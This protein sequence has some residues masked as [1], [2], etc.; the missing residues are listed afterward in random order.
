MNL[1]KI[2]KDFYRILFVNYAY[3][4][5]LFHILLNVLPPFLRKILFKAVLGKLGKKVFIDTNVYFRY[6]QKVEIGSYVSINR[7]CEFYPSLYI[8]DA[9]IR[10]GNNVRFGPNVKCYTAGHD[11]KYLTLPDTAHKIMVK[12]NVW[13]GANAI[14]LPGVTINEGCV[15]AAGS[16]VTKTTESYYI[17]AGVPAKKIKKR[18]LDDNQSLKT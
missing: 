6:P 17:Y 13:I 18:L 11:Y 3:L 14:I 7:G 9:I 1:K 15:V 4:I 16:V 8:K 2:D 10:I 12:D 5:N